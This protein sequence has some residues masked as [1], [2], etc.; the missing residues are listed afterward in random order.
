[1]ADSTVVRCDGAEDKPLTNRKCF[2]ALVG[3]DGCAAHVEGRFT[4]ALCVCPRAPTAKTQNTQNTV[5]GNNLASGTQGECVGVHLKPS[6][7][8]HHKKVN[9]HNAECVRASEAEHVLWEVGGKTVEGAL[10]TARPWLQSFHCLNVC[11]FQAKT[12][13]KSFCLLCRFHGFPVMQQLVNKLQGSSLDAV[14]TSSWS[15]SVNW[16]HVVLSRVGTLDGLCLG[17]PPDPSKDCSVPQ[18]HQ[19]MLEK[20]RRNRVPAEFGC[21]R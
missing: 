4:P 15:C 19:C 14:C 13:Q 20:L 11:L 7:T 8:V 17:E 9:G 18:N 21:D 2:W 12:R 5:V 1:L 10:N 16:P 3:E 6:H